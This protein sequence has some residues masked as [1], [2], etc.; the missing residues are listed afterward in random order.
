[1]RFLNDTIE[2]LEIEN[3]FGV[4]AVVDKREFLKV[5]FF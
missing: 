1:M 2:S 3:L 4:V 5:S